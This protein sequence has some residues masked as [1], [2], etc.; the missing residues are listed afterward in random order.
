MSQAIAGSDTDTPKIVEDKTRALPENQGL[1]DHA[2]WLKIDTEID[3]ARTAT[4]LME[5]EAYVAADKHGNA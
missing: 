4:N 2:M 3:E 5:V 1:N